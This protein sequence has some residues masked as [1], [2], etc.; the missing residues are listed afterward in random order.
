MDAKRLLLC[1]EGRDHTTIQAFA[2]DLK[3]HGSEP[4]VIAHA[5]MNMSAAY[6]KGTAA[7]L[8]NALVSYRRFH[9]VK[10]SG[11]AMDEVRKQE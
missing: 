11:E 6:L 8:P 4:T 2:Q 10:L 9:I 1:T 7:H 3:D 5:C